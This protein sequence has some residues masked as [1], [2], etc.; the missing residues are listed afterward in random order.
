MESCM[1]VTQQRE[2]D[3]P[4]KV[5]VL[6]VPVAT[7]AYNGVLFK[8]LRWVS[9]QQCFYTSESS[10]R[11]VVISKKSVCTWASKLSMKTQVHQGQFCPT[12]HAFGTVLAQDREMVH[13]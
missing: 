10:L 13:V 1:L 12:P 2:E 7:A 6:E 11:K 5:H 8:L 3:K 9:V 4:K